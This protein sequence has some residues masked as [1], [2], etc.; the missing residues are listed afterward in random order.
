MT[1]YEIL[2]LFRGYVEMEA[3]SFTLFLTLASGYL[4]VAHLAGARL[5][6][7][8][9]IIVSVLFVAGATLQTWAIQQYQLAIREL[10]D[11]KEKISPLTAFQA[12]VASSSATDVF[13]VLM[14]LGIIA[15]LWFMWSVRHPKTK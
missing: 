6:R 15:S 9:T 10:L 7:L 2:D 13:A 12:D 4:I 11:A 5:S 8:Q 14:S 1:E 3:V